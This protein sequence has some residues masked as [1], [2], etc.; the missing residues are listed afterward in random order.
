MGK[1][2]QASCASSPSVARA[3]DVS[4]VI[5]NTLKYSMRGVRAAA[6]AAFAQSAPGPWAAARESC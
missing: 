1:G 2:R 6:V 3:R 5:R 4:C